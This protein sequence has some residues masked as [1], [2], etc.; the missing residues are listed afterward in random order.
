MINYPPAE[1]L[2]PHSRN[3][4]LLDRIISCDDEGLRAEVTVRRDNIFAQESG[5]PA[6][7]GIELMAQAIAAFA[8]IKAR[9]KEQEIEIG[10]LVGT[11]RYE[12]NTPFFPLDCTLTIDVKQELQA[13]NGLGVFLCD[14]SS[15]KI[16]AK[17]S[18]NVFQPDNVEEFLNQ[19]ISNRHHE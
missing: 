3:M 9:E 4:S 14:I 8:G 13:E 18:I 6:S 17:A 10:F 15:D 2:V 12:S 11:R 7:V 5:L 19:E 16:A 1:D